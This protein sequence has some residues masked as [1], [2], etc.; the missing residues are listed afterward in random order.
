MQSDYIRLLNAHRI[1]ALQNDIIG[2]AKVI[3]CIQ[4][5]QSETFMLIER[6]L[7]GFPSVLYFKTAYPN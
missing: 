6:I 1:I 4:T 2:L 7:Q 3:I 5:F